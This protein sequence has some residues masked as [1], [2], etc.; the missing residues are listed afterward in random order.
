M[1]STY[2]SGFTVGLAIGSIL[3][4][5]LTDRYGP[6]VILL[7]SDTFRAVISIGAIW[8][9]GHLV[10]TLGMGLLLGLLGGAAAV[11]VSVVPKKIIP[12]DQMTVGVSSLSSAGQLLFLII[13]VASAGLMALSMPTLRWLLVALLYVVAA[14]QFALMPNF[15][16]NPRADFEMPAFNIR[17]G[18]REVFRAPT[19]VFFVL[20]GLISGSTTTGVMDVAFPFVASHAARVPSG[21]YGFLL[22]IWGTGLMM[23]SLGAGIYTPKTM[24]RLAVGSS[25]LCFG[26]IF[27]VYPHFWSLA[28][29]FVV[30]GVLMGYLRT[31]STTL[32]IQRVPEQSLG[33]TSGFVDSL[34]LIVQ[35]ISI[36]AA[37]LAI[38]LRALNPYLLINAAV[39]LAV[40]LL[41]A[42]AAASRRVD[43]A[44]VG[45]PASAESD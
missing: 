18:F 5:F 29:G 21:L 11:A 34:D 19:L 13:P 6:R 17:A 39:V 9:L 3:G 14:V 32:M 28:V 7:A 20:L 2:L 12:A 35:P 45:T 27:G 8:A 31:G 25:L 44:L 30:L 26:F 22:P 1:L 41:V 33:K 15:G 4:G 10:P 42:W 40:S 36:W 24:R 43:A 16:G 23:G 37:D 38:S